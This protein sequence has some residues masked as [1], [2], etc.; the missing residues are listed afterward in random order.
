[1]TRNLGG[2]TRIPLKADIK[3]LSVGTVFFWVNNK[4]QNCERTKTK[5][6]I[7]PRH[8]ICRTSC[9]CS[10]GVYPPSTRVI[11]GSISVRPNSKKPLRFFLI[12]PQNLTVL[13][14]L[15]VKR[16]MRPEFTVAEHTPAMT[17]TSIALR[18][19]AVA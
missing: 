1:M 16:Q 14:A 17:S 7:V 2:L 19:T 8:S 4:N 15:P 3:M 10:I 18:R 5:K 13:P 9:A 6:I 12:I 11:R